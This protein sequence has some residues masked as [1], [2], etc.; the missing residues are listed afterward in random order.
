V[1]LNRDQYAIVSF[2]RRIPLCHRFADVN[3]HARL[4]GYV[5]RMVQAACM[6]CTPRRSTGLVPVD[7]QEL[8][9]R[10]VRAILRGALD[11]SAEA[12]LARILGLS[13]RHLRRVF[14]KEIGTTPAQFA[15][16]ARGEFAR[17]LLHETDLTVT[18]VARLA[19]FGSLR[20]LERTCHEL[21]G[22]A[23]RA[24]RESGTHNSGWLEVEL[25]SAGVLDWPRA[26]A[27]L[28]ARAVP[29]VE[30]V[31]SP[32]QRLDDET[33]AILVAPYAESDA[34][35]VRV[36]MPNWEELVHVIAKIRRLFSI[37]FPLSVEDD[38]ALAV[39]VELDGAVASR[40]GR[41]RQVIGA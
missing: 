38:S 8:V 7:D 30:Y 24:L 11:C 32:A 23:P 37:E 41:P 33:A 35:A 18:E 27:R 21:Y 36:R 28:R 6:Q 10:A 22:L 39:S 15:R 20:Q 1:V 5:G 16:F 19:G 40:Y 9:C 29:G 4:R 25:R 34:L 2:M 14:K 12:D 26:V 31:D 13:G 17:R 3:H